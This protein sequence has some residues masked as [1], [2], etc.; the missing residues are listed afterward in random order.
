[1]TPGEAFVIVTVFAGWT[2]M[3]LPTSVDTNVALF[4]VNAGEPVVIAPSYRPWLGPRVSPFAPMV[5]TLT[6]SADHWTA[7][8]LEAAGT[9]PGPGVPENGVAVSCSRV[10]AV[11]AQVAK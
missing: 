5:L 9:K 8:E 4:D 10:P 3:T 11:L 6:G 7:D 1:M 2:R